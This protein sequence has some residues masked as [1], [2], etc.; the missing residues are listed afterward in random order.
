MG[1]ASDVPDYK[2]CWLVN[3]ALS[4]GFKRMDDLELYHRKINENQVFSLFQFV[5]ENK[6]LTYRIIK[7]RCAN[8]YFLEGVKNLDFLIHIQ[9]EIMMDDVRELIKNIMRISDI[10]LCIPVNINKI[11][12]KSRLEIW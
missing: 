8:G 12:D 1:I 6:L 11:P 10:R 5:D 2:L 9:G 7:N 4:M 3:N